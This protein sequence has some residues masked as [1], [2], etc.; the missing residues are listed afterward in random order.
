[1][2]ETDL[3]I[4]INGFLHHKIHNSVVLTQEIVNALIS[5][6]FVTF[7]EEE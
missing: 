4:L 1:M 3:C 6:G 5:E 2:T 7:E